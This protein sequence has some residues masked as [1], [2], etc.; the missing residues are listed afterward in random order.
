MKQFLSNISNTIHQDFII[1]VGSGEVEI[2]EEQ[3]EAKCKKVILKSQ[4]KQVFAFSLDRNLVNRCK[5]FPFFNKSTALIHK[6]NDGI[7]FYI[8]NNQIFVLLVELK[9]N[10]L[11]KYQEQLQAG[12]V[13]VYFLLGILNNAFAKNYVI[14]EKNIKCLVFSVKKTARKQ[15]TKRKA[16]EYEQINGLNIANDLQCHKTYYIENFIVR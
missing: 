15:G 3:S 5:V 13:F 10:H 7:V 14:E 9:S 8:N 16:I 2:K 6:V 11:G 4:S 12:K 1:P